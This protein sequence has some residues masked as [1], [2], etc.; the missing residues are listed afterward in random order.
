MRRLNMN[1]RNITLT[2]GIGFGVAIGLNA[3]SQPQQNSNAE[4]PTQSP[5]QFPAQTTKVADKDFDYQSGWL[6]IAVQGR[7]G[8]N[9][10]HI[11]LIPGLVSS[12]D[13]WKEA[14]AELGKTHALHLV[15]I[16]GFAGLAPTDIPA[17]GVINDIV[18]ELA[19]YIETQELKNVTIVGH[20]MGGFTALN[21]AIMHGG[22]IDKIIIV[23]SL[24]FYSALFNPEATVQTSRPQ[25]DAMR[26][27]ILAMDGKQFAQMQAGSA[28]IMSKSEA[29]RKDILA[30]SLASDRATMASAVYELMTQDLRED[31]AAITTKTHVIY[32]WD[33]AMRVPAAHIENIYKTQY[34]N[35]G[36]VHLTRIDNSFHFIMKDQ[37]KAFL[38][39][40]QIAL[41]DK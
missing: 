31:I 13:I 35:L 33:E 28:A 15:G 25:A 12:P 7:V 34:K 11:I 22:L 27:Q 36:A 17:Q 23:D 4:V 32:A 3:C 26:S 40:V 38:K 41:E 5:V 2:L 8:E 6:N 24:P 30:W 18:D 39:A 10:P 20:S 37:P 9:T 16:S 1:V 29:A 19:Q 14:S 21:M